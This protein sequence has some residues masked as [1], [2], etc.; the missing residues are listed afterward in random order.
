QLADY[1]AGSRAGRRCLKGLL[2]GESALACAENRGRHYL[3]LVA[4]GRRDA[5]DKDLAEGLGLMD[6]VKD[7]PAP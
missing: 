1:P 7:L 3:G 4:A 2:E 5:S 6:A